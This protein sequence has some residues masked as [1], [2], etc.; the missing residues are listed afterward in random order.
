MASPWHGFSGVFNDVRYTPA[1]FLV[2]PAKVFKNSDE[3]FESDGWRIFEPNRQTP[4]AGNVYL[5]TQW[6]SRYY[7][8]GESPLQK[9]PG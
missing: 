2:D 9:R 7:L 5:R 4:S 1:D 8:T 6:L 3:D